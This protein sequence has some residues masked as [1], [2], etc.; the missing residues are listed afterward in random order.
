MRRAG[1]VR[2]AHVVVG[3]HVG[4]ERQHQDLAQRFGE[5]RVATSNSAGRCR[6]RTFSMPN[7]EVTRPGSRRT[8]LGIVTCRLVVTLELSMPI[9]KVLHGKKY[10]SIDQEIE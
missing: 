9:S 3:E 2:L 1:R 8:V 10:S 6:R 5:R 4:V 7:P